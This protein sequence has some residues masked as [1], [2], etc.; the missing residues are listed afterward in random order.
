[1]DAATDCSPL[2]PGV[3]PSRSTLRGSNPA[4]TSLLVH[5]SSE[6]AGDCARALLPDTR[7]S[8]TAPA[9]SLVVRRMGPPP[10]MDAWPRPR[11]ASVVVVGPPRWQPI[12][13]LDWGLVARFRTAN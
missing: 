11:R 13:R 1:S 2:G 9:A 6:A 4:S 5:A 10:P 8:A 12:P 3:E 7:S